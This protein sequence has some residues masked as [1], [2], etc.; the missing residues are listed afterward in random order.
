MRS[1]VSTDLAAVVASLVKYRDEWC[2][3][4]LCDDLIAVFRDPRSRIDDFV[5][6]VGLLAGDP[7]LPELHEPA[8]R[9]FD[10]IETVSHEH[11]RR[12]LAA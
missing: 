12:L 2:D 10:L 3:L 11:L 1:T 9:L 5:F 8:E 7:S 6:N 4:A